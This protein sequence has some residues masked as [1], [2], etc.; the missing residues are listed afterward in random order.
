[1]LEQEH[2]ESE[3]KNHESKRHIKE[4]DLGDL[5]PDQKDIVTK[6]LYEE[7]ESFSNDDLD[8]GS[9]KDLQM[10]I[11]LSNS[12]QKT[13]LAVPR[14]LYPELKAYIEDIL[15]QGF[16]TK[17]Q[18]HYSQTVVCVRKKDNTMRLCVDFRE[19]NKRIIQDRHPLPRVQETLD[20]P[21]GSQWF[22]V[23]DQGKAYHQGFA[24]PDSRYLTAFV[25]PWG[26]YEWVRIPFGLTSAPATF[27][28]Y[29][30]EC[31]EDMRDEFCIPY[32]DD[33][34]M[35]SHSFSDHVDHVRAVLRRLG[36]KGIKLKA[37][38]CQLFKREVKYLGRLVSRDD[39]RIDPEAV[40]PI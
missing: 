25:T 4:V 30:E 26:L 3:S 27:Q 36:E 40:K 5:T 13:Y 8:I 9:A 10:E 31:L 20:S 11:R 22:S 21:G 12:K 32:L 17:S 39:Y 23:L 28:R 24:H 16:I 38:K 18:S 1:M 34:V 37:R 33:M 35:F 15:N 6:M 19:L 29:M 14:P 7:S 2:R